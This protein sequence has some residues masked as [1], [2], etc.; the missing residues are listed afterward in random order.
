MYDPLQRVL[1]LLEILSALDWPTAWRSPSVCSLYDMWFL[2]LRFLTEE[3]QPEVLF[4]PFA[5]QGQVQWGMRPAHHENRSV[6][7]DLVAGAARTPKRLIENSC[8]G[9]R[10]YTEI[11]GV[12]I[13]EA[14]VDPLGRVVLEHLPF[15]PG[16]RVD[17]SVRAH[18]TPSDKA[19][20]LCGSVIRYENPFDPVAT[21]DWGIQ[22]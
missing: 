14:T 5:N 13:A 2:W 6:W 20:D 1:T 3:G 7:T 4:T 21:D 12:H 10:T 16:D 19:L 9:P 15:R 17:V 8:S 22:P 11:M 18:D